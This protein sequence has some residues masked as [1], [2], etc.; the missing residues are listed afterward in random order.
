MYPH[1]GELSVCNLYVPTSVH[2]L[3]NALD[4]P[5]PIAMYT[6]ES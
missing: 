1:G 2:T 4:T 6:L 3:W 5:Q